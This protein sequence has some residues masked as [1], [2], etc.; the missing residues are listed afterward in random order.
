MIK[1]KCKILWYLELSYQLGNILKISG[2]EKNGI[3]AH[4]AVQQGLICFKC[5]CWGMGENSE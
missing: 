1:S 4:V 5:S 2:W 3:L